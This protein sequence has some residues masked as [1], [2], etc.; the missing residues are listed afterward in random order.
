[1]RALVLALVCLLLSACATQPPWEKVDIQQ[2]VEA[3]TKK[4][5]GYLAIGQLNQALQDFKVAL[6]LQ[7]KHSPALHG[8]A[9]VLEQQGE[10]ELAEDF[11]KQ[12]LKSAANSK[13]KTHSLSTQILVDLA[14]FYY[15]QQQF[16]LAEEYL[17]Q[18]SQD[19]YYPDRGLVFVNLGYT[20]SK[21][22]QT[23]QALASF[24]QAKKLSAARDLANNELLKLYV[25]Q[26]DWQAAES[27]WLELKDQNEYDVANLPLALEAVTAMNN[28]REIRLIE[29]LLRIRTHQN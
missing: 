24:Q 4:G 15:S 8:T 6:N 2:Q 28:H 17:Q 27:T 9:L 1:M 13:G 21:L 11:F 10:T 29:T 5:Q 16:T 23:E 3:Y 20:H 22:G 26:E 25:A 7:P 14:G 19:I 12:A 18:A